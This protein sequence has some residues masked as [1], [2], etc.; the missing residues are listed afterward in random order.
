MRWVCLRFAR[1]QGCVLSNVRCGFGLTEDLVK[2]IISGDKGR[3]GKNMKTKKYWTLAIILAMC[4]AVV[5]A[6]GAFAVLSEKQLSLAGIKTLCVFVQE[7]TE[8]TKKAGLTREQI[9]TDVERRLKREGIRVV[10]EEECAELA[11]SPV[12]YV[13]ISAPKMKYTAAFV[14]HIDLGLLQKVALVRDPKIRIMGVTWTRG[15]LGYCPERTF[16]TSVRETVEYL[17]DEFV[18][19]YLAANRKPQRAKE[20]F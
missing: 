8:E 2:V 19:D 12:L 11:G 15:R 18:E 4:L 17:M 7:L 6:A 1:D 3:K 5:W 9:Q 20:S 16:V 13:N 14:Y 10:S